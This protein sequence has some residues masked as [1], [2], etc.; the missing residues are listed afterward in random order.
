[1][2]LK[3]QQHQRCLRGALAPAPLSGSAED[4]EMVEGGWESFRKEDHF[5]HLVWRVGVHSRL[6]EASAEA[7]VAPAQ[8]VMALPLGATCPSRREASRASRS[9]VW[10]GATLIKSTA[11][12]H[13]CLFPI[14]CVDVFAEEAFRIPLEGGPPLCLLFLLPLQAPSPS[15]RHVAPMPARFRSFS[16]PSLSSSH[17]PVPFHRPSSCSYCASWR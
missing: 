7:S 14:A 6:E 1:M 3:K 17:L 9:L 15:V 8:L 4:R 13:N 10:H 5:A 12:S 2:S 16:S 11:L